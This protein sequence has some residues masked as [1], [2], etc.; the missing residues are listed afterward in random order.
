MRAL[1][2]FVCFVAT[3]GFS[4]LA[5]TTRSMASYAALAASIGALLTALA[6]LKKPNTQK[7]TLSQKIGDNSFG[8]QA[9]N[10]VNINKNKE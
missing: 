4:Y 7:K 5:F 2:A 8:I 10:D 1:I 6:N 9:G 3:C